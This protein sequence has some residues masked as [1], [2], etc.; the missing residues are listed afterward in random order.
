MLGRS[1]KIALGLLF[2]SWLL[3]TGIGPALD[4]DASRSCATRDL[5]GLWD[6]VR[7]IAR[8]SDKVDPKDAWF[9][10]HQRFLFRDNGTVQYTSSVQPLSDAPGT[11]A[12]E[13]VDVMAWTVYPDG[14]LELQRANVPYPE[15]CSCH[16]L[17]RNDKDASGRSTYRGQ[18]MLIYMK[19]GKPVLQKLLRKV[20]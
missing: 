16:F 15:S 17:L 5:L 13:T 1:W 10:P 2:A 19:D 11:D 6:M 18:I 7:L 14:W 9:F 20:Q 3:P 12:G 4:R 8:G